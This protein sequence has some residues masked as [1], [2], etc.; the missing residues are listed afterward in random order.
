M[1]WAYV[2]LSPDDEPADLAVHADQF[3]IGRED[4]L[5]L[6]LADA[7]LHLDEQAGVVGERL[8]G[9]VGHAGVP[10]GRSQIHTPMWLNFFRHWKDRLVPSTRCPG[11]NSLTALHSGVSCEH[12]SWSEKVNSTNARWSAGSAAAS[13]RTS[14]V[15]SCRR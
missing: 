14:A 4:S 12:G 1:G 10:S 15:Q 2:G 9:K 11:W 3:R 5:G 13:L 6:V 7:G 8:G